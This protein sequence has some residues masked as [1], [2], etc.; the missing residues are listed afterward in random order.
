MMRLRHAYTAF[1]RFGILRLVTRYAQWDHGV[2]AMTVLRRIVE[3]SEEDPERYPLLNFVARYFDHFNVAPTGW[4]AFF[5]EVG[6]FLDRE[7]GIGPSPEREVVLRA[8]AFLLPDVGRSFPDSL[9]LDHDVVTYVRDHTRGLWADGTPSGGGR[10][11]DYG[12]TELRVYGDPLDRCG[13]GQAVNQDPRNEVLTESF[14]IVG[15]WELDSPL[16]NNFSEVAGDGT[17]EGVGEQIPADL[18]EIEEP[19]P[20]ARR[21]TPVILSGVGSSTEPS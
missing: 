3:V 10:L 9:P 4:R 21:T 20:P 14:W 19:E 17:Y 13:A 6:D 8:Q 1:E 12:P 5:D 15:H 2:P 7:H 16:A 11:G 18:G